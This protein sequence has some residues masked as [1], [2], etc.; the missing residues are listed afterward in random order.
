MDDCK[1]GEGKEWRSHGLWRERGMRSSRQG[2]VL[3]GREGVR[4]GG[5]EGGE[6]GRER[7]EDRG[8]SMKYSWGKWSWRGGKRLRE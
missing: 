5:R 7:G 8:G 6:D 1:S 2:P 4:E 3:G